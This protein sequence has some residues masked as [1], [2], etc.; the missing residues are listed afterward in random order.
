M[1]PTEWADQRKVW[2]N[3]Y[4]LREVYR[5]LFR[6]ITKQCLPGSLLEIGSGIGVFKDNRPDI[7]ALDVAFAPWLDMVAD[8]QRLP[9]NS[10]SF[11]NIVA[12]DVL[13]HLPRPLLFLSE[14]QRTLRP[15][16]RL[17]L[18]EPAITAGSWFFYRFIHQERVRMRVD[19]FSG[20]AMCSEDPYDA[21]Q[22]IPT[23]LFGRLSDRLQR[24]LPGL[25]LVTVD[26]LSVLAYP[27]SGGFK[28]WSL[29]PGILI[30]P[31][32]ALENLL[33]PTVK[34]WLGFRLLAVL[35][36]Q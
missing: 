13:H 36:K 2:N 28:S 6:H 35:S 31:V 30:G 1:I 12:V 9:V 5:D 22:A 7:I 14:A 21:N 34:R 17:I 33:P 20:E 11:D 8:A 32:L 26:Y 10:D 23:L 25:R 4:V 29:L 27:L 19:P 16:G 3:K 18:L 24:E 15:G